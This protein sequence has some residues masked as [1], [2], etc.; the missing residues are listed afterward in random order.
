ML[1]VCVYITVISRE[2][3]E[4]FLYVIIPLIAAIFILEVLLYIAYESGEI[5]ETIKT[6]RTTK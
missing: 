6:D 1:G 4:N 5:D 2:I 3:T